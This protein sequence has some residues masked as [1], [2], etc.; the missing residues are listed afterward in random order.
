MTT[1]ESMTP[2]VGEVWRYTSPFGGAWSDWRIEPQASVCVG[3]SSGISVGDRRNSINP[4]NPGWTRVSLAPAPSDWRA[5]YPVGSECEVRLSGFGL[6]VDGWQRARVVEHVEDYMRLHVEAAR[7][8]VFF[9]SPEIRALASQQDR[10]RP[11]QSAPAVHASEPVAVMPATEVAEKPAACPHCTHALHRAHTVDVLRCEAC[12]WA[13]TVAQWL[14]ASTQPAPEPRFKVGDWVKSTVCSGDWQVMAVERDPVHGMRYTV[15][16]RDRVD[17]GPSGE[18][19]I[20][21]YETNGLILTER[22]R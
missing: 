4:T 15:C 3:S 20:V 8:S 14:A 2:Q 19:H 1:S 5:A 21:L 18:L 9:R 10:I 13:G 16:S 7:R 12:G 11:V 17:K 6:S 22:P